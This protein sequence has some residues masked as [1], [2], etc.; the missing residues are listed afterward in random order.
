MNPALIPHLTPGE[1]HPDWE[2]LYEKVPAEALPWHLEGL[3]PDMLAE[4]KEMGKIKRALD[5]GCGLGSQAAALTELGIETTGTD[6][7][8]A[9][10][11]RA[12][13]LYP[14]TRFI[15]DDAT[16]TALTETHDLILDRGC[17]HVL[18]ETAYEPYLKS[19]ETLL[20]P[21]GRFLLKAFSLENGSSPF[22]PLLFTPADLVRLFAPRFRILKMRRTFF[23]GP[24]SRSPVAWFVVMRRKDPNV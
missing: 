23:Q 19:L 2:R 12:V 20:E 24:S 16:D 21:R 1:R 8:S 4:I 13:V 5:L 10:V 18:A 14:K 3:D 17:F 7:S 11:R 6:I 15:V 9:A 22:G